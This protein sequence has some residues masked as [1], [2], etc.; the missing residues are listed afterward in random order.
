MKII[1]KNTIGLGT[2]ICENALPAEILGLLLDAQR[3][4]STGIS[5]H[6][7]VWSGYITSESEAKQCERDHW[8]ARE[9]IIERAKELVAG[10][11]PLADAKAQAEQEVSI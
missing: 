3:A 11:M 7:P 8:S 2:V 6:S 5:V 9:M 1:V 4:G 10:G